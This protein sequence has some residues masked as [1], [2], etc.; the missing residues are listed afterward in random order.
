LGKRLAQIA[1]PWSVP[2]LTFNIITGEYITQNILTAQIAA[3]SDRIAPVI[4]Y[5]LNPGMVAEI[6]SF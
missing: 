3:A 5:Q 6:V 1:H 4:N 2:D